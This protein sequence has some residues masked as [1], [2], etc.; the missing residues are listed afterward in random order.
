MPTGRA[1]REES[2]AVEMSGSVSGVP[3]SELGGE[4][5][6]QQAGACW[7]HRTQREALWEHCGSTVGA[8]EESAASFPQLHPEAKVVASAQHTEVTCHIT[9]CRA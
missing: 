6:C 1:V 3:P 7:V 9:R 4:A 5:Q 2:P 8:L